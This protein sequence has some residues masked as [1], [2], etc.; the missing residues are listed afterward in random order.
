MNLEEL[1][2][3]NK[4]T[5]CSVNPQVQLQNEIGTQVVAK[6]TTWKPNIRQ[7]GRFYCWLFIYRK[8]YSTLE[9]VIKVSS[10]SWVRFHWTSSKVLFG[11]AACSLNRWMYIVLKRGASILNFSSLLC[12]LGWL[13]NQINSFKQSTYK[14]LANY[15]TIKL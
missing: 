3:N 1:W 15:N 2:I 6:P 10:S 13:E 12:L 5:H 8:L 9:F 4:H 7:S 11:S 14:G